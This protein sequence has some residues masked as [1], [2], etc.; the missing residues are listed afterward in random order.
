MFSRSLKETVPHPPNESNRYFIL[1]IA[2]Y[3]VDLDCKTKKNQVILGIACKYRNGEEQGREEKRKGGREGSKKGGREKKR[4][5][6]MNRDRNRE[7]LNR[8]LFHYPLHPGTQQN[9]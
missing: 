6:E 1:Y 3:K 7:L 5:G 9:I 4:E 2:V 8:L